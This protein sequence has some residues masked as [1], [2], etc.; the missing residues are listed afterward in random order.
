MEIKILELNPD[1]VKILFVGES[2]T[3]MNAL[4][5]EIL[6]DPRVDVASYNPQLHFTDPELYVSTKDGVDPI[7]VIIDAARRISADCAEL[8]DAI[9]KS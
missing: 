8:L 6:T 4:T 9:A 1:S 7:A 2:H 5:Q 3:Y